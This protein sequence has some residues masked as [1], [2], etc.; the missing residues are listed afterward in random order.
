MTNL[1]DFA[2][3]KMGKSKPE[4][5]DLW[6]SENDIYIALKDNRE[7]PFDN[8]LVTDKME[9]GTVM[10]FAV[11]AENAQSKHKSNKR[12]TSSHTQDSVF[13]GYPSGGDAPSPNI[14]QWTEYLPPDETQIYALLVKYSYNCSVVSVNFDKMRA[15]RLSGQGNSFRKLPNRFAWSA[16]V[17]VKFAWHRM[18]VVN[19]PALMQLAAHDLAASQRT[20]I[21]QMRSHPGSEWLVTNRIDNAGDFAFASSF[22]LQASPFPFTF[23][24]FFLHLLLSFE[25][26]HHTFTIFSYSKSDSFS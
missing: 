26:F 11:R 14:L 4:V 19:D 2:L 13:Q 21:V 18:D 24:S 1:I 12:H 3:S 9:A 10:V 15:F 20:F 23:L 6:L 22:Y 25:N 7:A 16:L 5:S 17:G 8:L